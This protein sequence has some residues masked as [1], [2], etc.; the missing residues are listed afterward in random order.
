[1]PRVYIMPTFGE[2]HQNVVCLLKMKQICTK[3]DG[4]ICHFWCWVLDSQASLSQYL[5]TS[6]FTARRCSF[7]SPL[8]SSSW[9][10]SCYRLVPLCCSA[11]ENLSCYSF[12]TFQ[13]PRE[14]SVI[15]T[16]KPS[17][18]SLYCLWCGPPWPSS[19]ASSHWSWDSGASGKRINWTLKQYDQHVLSV[20]K[21]T[22]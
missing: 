4:L 2:S 19:S 17:R 7:F 22:H 10:W 18:S 15:S 11:G 21:V 12:T 14:H 9:S 8:S 5:A 16:M 1:M 6:I 13:T 3:G 20:F